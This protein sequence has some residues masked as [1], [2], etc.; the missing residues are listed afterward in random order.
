MGRSW[1]AYDFLTLGRIREQEMVLL[2]SCWWDDATVAFQFLNVSCFTMNQ[3]VS[4][5]VAPYVTC[6]ENVRPSF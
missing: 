2:I 1:T 3:I 4:A 5:R 6:D